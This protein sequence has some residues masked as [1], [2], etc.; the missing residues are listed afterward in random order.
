[1]SSSSIVFAILKAAD[2]D[3]TAAI[4]LGFAVIIHLAGMHLRISYS[5]INACEDA[6]FRLSYSQVSFYIL[7]EY[8]GH[9]RDFFHKE[10]FSATGP[11]PF[12]I[13]QQGLRKRGECK[14][15]SLS[16]T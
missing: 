3:K 14:K 10:Y 4:F 9:L 12:E 2:L 5:L 16:Q 11:R 7:P 15:M 8:C 6:E 13:H 1:M